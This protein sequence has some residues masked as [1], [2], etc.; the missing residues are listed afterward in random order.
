MP[1]DPQKVK[2]MQKISSICVNQ[3]NFKSTT[4]NSFDLV[5]L[6]LTVNVTALLSPPGCVFFL[7]NAGKSSR[8]RHTCRM[9]QTPAIV[10]FFCHI[11]STYISWKFRFL[12]SRIRALCTVGIRNPVPENQTKPA[13]MDNRSLTILNRRIQSRRLLDLRQ[14]T[15]KR[16]KLSKS[17][18]VQ[19]FSLSGSSQRCIG[20]LCPGRRMP[21][22]TEGSSI[23]S[24]TRPSL[25]VLANYRM[26]KQPA[27]VRL[28]L[29]PKVLGS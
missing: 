14:D 26:S 23:S 24:S 15:S 21:L 28:F 17:L 29:H 1:D 19:E 13:K 20:V 2:K 10:S 6:N 9:W 7:R 22:L 18:Q 16:T 4:H 12:L 8:E 5:P 3:S 11:L 27:F 25:V